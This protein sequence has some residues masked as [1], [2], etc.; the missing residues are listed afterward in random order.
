MRSRKIAMYAFRRSILISTW[1]VLAAALVGVVTVGAIQ[2]AK[3]WAPSDNPM[4]VVACACVPMAIGG[5]IYSTASAIVAYW[6]SRH[7]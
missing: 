5:L 6:R 1:T 4:W 3:E 7:G 2:T